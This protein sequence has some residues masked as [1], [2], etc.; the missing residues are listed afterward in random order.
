MVNARKVPLQSKPLMSNER[1]FDTSFLKKKM[2]IKG[3]TAIYISN[4][5]LLLKL[6]QKDGGH[7]VT[8]VDT[9][10]ITGFRK[11]RGFGSPTCTTIKTAMVK[12]NTT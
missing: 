8:R 2:G 4:I 3:M 9:A 11:E 1:P 12:D 7:Q 5:I 6:G 10:K